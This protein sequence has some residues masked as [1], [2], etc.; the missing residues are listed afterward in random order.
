[1]SDIIVCEAGLARVI[2][3]RE[4]LSNVGSGDLPL[5]ALPVPLGMT[6]WRLA[7]EH[8]QIITAGL[9]LSWLYAMFS[10]STIRQ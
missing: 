4:T 9:S 6:K 8:T 5:V 2:K 10:L 7:A 3:W 1:M